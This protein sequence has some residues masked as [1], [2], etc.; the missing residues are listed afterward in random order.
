[1]TMWT[2]AGQI[3]IQVCLFQFEAS[4][5]SGGFD[6]IA[7]RF[8]LALMNQILVDNPLFEQGDVWE[9]F[10]YL[11]DVRFSDSADC[12]QCAQPGEVNT[13]QGEI[14]DKYNLQDCEIGNRCRC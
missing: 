6:K 7:T 2:S 14:G 10:L 9:S 3:A 11:P 8:G 4:A 13:W 1:M 12:S 5:G